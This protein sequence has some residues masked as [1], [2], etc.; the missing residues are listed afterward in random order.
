MTAT[1]YY[2]PAWWRCSRC[3]EQRLQSQKPEQP[4]NCPGKAT[5]S[6][7]VW[8]PSDGYYFTAAAHGHTP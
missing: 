2:R 4:H 5:D 7:P 1:E 8:V 6:A 3:G